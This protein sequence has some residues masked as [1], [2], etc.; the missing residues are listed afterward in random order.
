MQTWTARI[1]Q[2][3]STRMQEEAACNDN[4]TVSKCNYLH[5]VSELALE[6]YL[7]KLCGGRASHVPG[8]VA[9]LL[10]PGYCQASLH[11][12]DA[13]SIGSLI[14][15]WVPG[16]ASVPFYLQSKVPLPGPVG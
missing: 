5:H 11:L 3:P 1:Q 14:W 8:R 13:G 6:S 15:G 16:W 10:P 9:L 12:S 7:G 2:A 4:P